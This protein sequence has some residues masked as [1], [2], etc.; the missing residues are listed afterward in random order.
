VS[1]RDWHEW[2]R[3]YDEPGSEMAQRLGVVRERIRIA[4]DEA[5]PGPLTTISMVA[6]EGRDL[7]P[8]LAAHPRR[9]DVTGRLVELDPGLAASARETASAA[10]LAG[11]NVATGDAAEL[12][13]YRPY[14]PADLVL[15]C[16]LF[17]N[18]IDEDI[19]RTVGYAPSLAKRGGTVI[20]T[21]YR[22]DDDLFPVVAD[23]FV[24][25]GF[26][27][28]FTSDTGHRYGVG[29]HRSRV[30]PPPLPHG[31]TAFTFVGY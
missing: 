22:S 10:G 8:V 19:R 9:S 17:G 1:Q 13:R 14:A 16:G 7:L 29:V 15:I 30:D 4:L 6:G 12:D 27:E 23:W 28:V 18:I 26:D 31:V 5:P 21:R 3:R 2:H 25:V 24:R 11:I 20:W